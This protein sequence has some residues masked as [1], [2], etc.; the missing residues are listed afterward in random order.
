MMV[1]RPWKIVP[2][3]TATVT[4]KTASVLVGGDAGKMG[5]SSSPSDDDRD[6]SSAASFLF[7]PRKDGERG[8]FMAGETS[9]AAMSE[10]SAFLVEME[11]INEVH[12]RRHLPPQARLPLPPSLPF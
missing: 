5:K 4:V 3:Y 6:A 11:V 8:M 9:K 1:M 2:L 12:S 10:S 7:V